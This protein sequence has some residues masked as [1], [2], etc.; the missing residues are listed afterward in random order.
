MGGPLKT[1]SVA[2]GALWFASLVL[3]AISFK[4]D[5]EREQ[6]LWGYEVLA[7][8][9]FHLLVLEFSW[10]ANFAFW[11]V[12]WRLWQHDVSRKALLIS[13]LALGLLTVQSFEIF[14]WADF[15][16]EPRPHAGYFAWI[17]AN[18]LLAMCAWVKGRL[19]G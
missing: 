11:Y 4:F 19:S 13:A 15:F 7:S 12:M 1:A 14:I 5:G 2:A 18:I 3:P 8:G 10:L 16:Q 6:I 17:G 9:Y